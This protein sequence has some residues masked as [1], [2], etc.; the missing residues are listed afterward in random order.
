MRKSLMVF[1]LVSFAFLMLAFFASAGT[2]TY[3]GVKK[4]KMCHR[5]EYKSWLQSKHANAWKSL[6]PAEQKNPKCA[7]CHSTKLP[8]ITGVTCEKCHG[9]GSGY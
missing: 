9:P 4:C 6:K 3:V 1:I 2:N 8:E 7:G 5:I